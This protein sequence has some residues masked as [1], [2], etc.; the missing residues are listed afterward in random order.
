MDI[1]RGPSLQ[2]V[3]DSLEIQNVKALYCEAVDLLTQE[4]ARERGLEMLRGVFAADATADYGAELH[5][6]Q[7]AILKFLCDLV[8]GQREWIQHVTGSPW[9]TVA[10]DHASGRWTC[11][12]H[13]VL[14]GTHE[15]RTLIGRY[16]DEFVR[17]AEGWKISR[18]VFR[19]EL[20]HPLGTIVE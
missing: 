17:T 2:A 3:A 18:I 8:G 6:G 20:E 14:A 13:M 11:S 5:K 9:V 7:A 19:R 10:G 15:R 1:S 16:A 12:A 4:S